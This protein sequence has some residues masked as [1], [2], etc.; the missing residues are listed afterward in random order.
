VTTTSGA[1]FEILVDGKPSYRDT[2][3]IA[4]EAAAYLKARH[5]KARLR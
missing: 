5:P 2:K 1:Q 3:V 4:I